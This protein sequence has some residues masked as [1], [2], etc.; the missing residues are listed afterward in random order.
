M[1][2]ISIKNIGPI[3]AISLPVPENGGV[4]V[5]TGRN[6]S[7]KSTALE[8]VSA[9]VSGKGK[10]PL[11]DLAERGEVVAG[12][13]KLTVGRNVRRAG[14]LEVATLEGR[15]SVADLVDPGISDPARAD[16][17]RIKALVGLSGAA[18]GKD[19][20]FG[21]QP[22]MLDGL[23]LSDPVSA[24]AE[25]KRRL[26]IGAR[27][28]EKL[29]K[30]EGD[31]AAAMLAQA[32]DAVSPFDPDA[33]M[34]AV[35]LAQRELD[36]LL[37][38]KSAADKAVVQATEARKKLDELPMAAIKDV[39]Q[40]ERKQVFYVDEARR[41]A[42]TLKEQYNAAVAAFN[43]E[44]SALEV[45]RAELKAAQ[46]SHTLRLNLEAFI[47]SG[48]VSAPTEDAISAAETSLSAAKKALESATK[49]RLAADLR[50]QGIEKAEEADRLSE[51]AV[52]LRRKAKQTDEVLSEIVA[53]IPGCPL[54][55]SDGRLVIS[56]G[57][58]PT[59]FGELSHGERWRVALDIAIGSVGA[60]GLLAIPQEAWE[61]LDSDNRA[62]VASA[63]KAGN[64]LVITAECDDGP[65]S[66]KII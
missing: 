35:M 9:A 57:R 28:Y 41:V 2:E 43:R 31:K 23:D 45:C 52:S 16:A 39:E 65:L 20:L 38:E 55:V 14:E 60:G 13:V 33:A 5:L 30:A 63:A 49:S 25:L 34:E 66:A 27:E 64:V 11:K 4:V 26:D 7:G 51:E 36:R 15:L 44:A 8:A 18:L 22:E 37:A 1:K 46:E 58:G 29:A 10:P 50:R 21:F 48:N 47:E 61:G 32:G 3:A 12:G 59:L 19:E 6:G 56:T 40:K 53:S 42:Q 24:M 62:A 17:T 54:K